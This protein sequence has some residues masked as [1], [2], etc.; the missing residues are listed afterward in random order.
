M[1]RWSNQTKP[2]LLQST[3]VLLEK[4]ACIADEKPSEA[5]PSTASSVKHRYIFKSVEASAEFPIDSQEDVAGALPSAPS[6]PLKEY[7]D[8]LKAI[9]L[10][11]KGKDKSEIATMLG[12]SEH[13]VKRWWRQQP[14]TIPKPKVRYAPLVT[15]APLLSFRDLELRRSFAPGGDKVME[16]LTSLLAWEPA[17]RAT[18]NPDTG[19]LKVRFDSAGRSMTQPGRFVAEYKGGIATLDNILQHV[20]AVANIRDPGLRIFLNRYESGCATC[21]MHRHDFWTAMVSFGTDRIA[22]IE[23]RPMLLRD[24]DLLVFGTQSHGCPEMPDIAERRISLVVFFRPD[25]DNLERRWLSLSGPHSEPQDDDLIGKEKET[26]PLQN[27]C[28][29]SAP[30][31]GKLVDSNLCGCPGISLGLL[32]RR[33]FKALSPVSVYTLGCHTLPESLVVQ[34]LKTSGIDEVWDIRSFSCM[35]GSQ[36]C[37]NNMRRMCSCHSVRYIH[38]PLGYAEAGGMCGHVKSEQGRDTLARMVLSAS[39]GR[40]VAIMG[41]MECWRECERQVVART[42]VS[43]ILGPVSVLHIEPG[44][45]ECHP[46]DYIL[47]KWLSPVALAERS[48]VDKPEQCQLLEEEGNHDIEAPCTVEPAHP[49]P[50]VRLNRFRRSNTECKGV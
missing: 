6:G 2:G 25:A 30:A 24:G 8:K 47:P 36:W 11:E 12:R 7:E 40:Q 17:R 9:D 4:P 19:E 16:E 3:D 18:R 10:R 42:L 13:W 33:E 35:V 32:A 39:Q 31:V 44:G 46:V 15:N 22:L 29:P 28:L 43:G 1:G 26:D 37:P 50:E 34:R 21:P 20:T 38:V 14:H 23:D 27:S 45:I 41:H 48:I 5:A 49:R